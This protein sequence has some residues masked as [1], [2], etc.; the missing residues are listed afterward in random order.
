MW[1]REVLGALHQRALEADELDT[2]TV[3]AEG[4]VARFQSQ[5]VGTVDLVPPALHRG[6]VGGVL[7]C[8]AVQVLA[9]GEELGGDVVLLGLCGQQHAEEGDQGRG[10]AGAFVGA[11]DGGKRVLGH[12]GGFGEGCEKAGTA[13]FG[14]PAGN[15]T[16]AGQGFGR[17][18]V[19]CGDLQEGLVLEQALAGDVY[20]L[21][22]AFAP[23]G[24]GLT[25]G[26]QAAV[27][28]AGTKALPHGAGVG[29]VGGGIVQDGH[30]LGDPGGAA[31]LFEAGAQA[32]VDG[33]EVRNVGGG[34][35]ELAGGEGA[36]GPV[37]E[38]VGLVDGRTGEGLDEDI[39]A[40]L[41][42]EACHHGGDLGV[43]ERGWD[44][45]EE[46][47]EDLDVLAG[48]V[49]DFEDAGV[50]EKGAEGGEVEA[51]SLGVDDRDLGVA[52]ELDEAEFGEVGALA[53]ELG[54]DGD[55]G[56]GSQAVAEGC[57]GWLGVDETGR[58]GAGCALG[59]WHFSLWHAGAGA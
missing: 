8:E 15:A 32:F 59:G 33:A 14:E 5:G 22:F 37:A 19:G 4:D 3:H 18:R 21:G 49:E 56:L 6:D 31:V 36:G 26:D 7:G 28:R 16:D 20:A 27:G 12:S 42:A 45:A 30:L 24:S 50:G 46:L 38:A 53:H 35:G 13:A 9:G 2:L 29:A 51:W 54:V 11:G 23:G 41:V 55:P 57:E 48:G 10:W 1:G 44:G 43:E 34:V 58:S 47:Q 52:G 17:R 40:D 25:Q 39:V